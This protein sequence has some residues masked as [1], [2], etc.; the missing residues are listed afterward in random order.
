VEVVEAFSVTSLPFHLN[1]RDTRAAWGRRQEI[2]VSVIGREWDSCGG[3]DKEFQNP[4][5]IEPIK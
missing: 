4:L 1:P 2:I 5:S 3:E